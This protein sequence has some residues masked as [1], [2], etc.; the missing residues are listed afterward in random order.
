MARLG[1]IA[2]MAVFGLFWTG[3]TCTFDGFIVDAMVKQSASEKY[4]SV[5]GVV[6]SSTVTSHRGS[7]GGTTYGAEVKFD[8]TV[9]GAAYTGDKYAYGAW[10]S[11]SSRSAAE[12]IVKRHPAGAT[13]MV[14]YNPARPSD[15]VLETS[16]QPTTLFMCLF[17]T[18]FNLI[19]IGI[20]AAALSAAWRAITK[21]PA[22][23]LK[24]VEGDGLTLVRVAW[25]RPFVTGLAVMGLAAFLST[26]VLAFATGMNPSM[27]VIVGV[28]IG[29]A[30][31]GLAACV[32]T[33]V[34]APKAAKFIVI[35]SAAKTLTLPA[36]GRGESA[37]VIPL[38]DLKGIQIRKEVEGKVRHTTLVFE[39]AGDG[40][41][42]TAG[43]A[44]PELKADTI[45]G[46]AEGLVA[47]LT[48]RCVKSP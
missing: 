5:A 28:L 36:L 7:K 26:F 14:Y 25:G 34:R 15:A 6:R 4:S 24:V 31:L 16:L 3:L 19:M 12:D 2:I 41:A 23:G 44:N 21:P 20:W 39:T 33:V 45:A 42:R 35:D 47:F 9:N 17:M 13:T 29:I 30:A 8:Y 37:R 46:K 1:G 38:A 22:G 32:G 40:E 18:P 27:R 11:S 43:G 48:D 10:V